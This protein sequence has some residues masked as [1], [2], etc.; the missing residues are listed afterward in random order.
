MELNKPG[1]E[2]A[3]IRGEI[4][5]IT[6]FHGCPHS[7]VP[8]AAQWVETLTAAARVTAEAWV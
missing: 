4:G 3:S 6:A 2:K 7:G 1:E 5:R 8:T